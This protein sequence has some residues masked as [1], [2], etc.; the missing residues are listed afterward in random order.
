MQESIQQSMNLEKLSEG[1]LQLSRGGT[2]LPRETII[3]KD[4][5]SEAIKRVDTLA[6]E[7]NI[8]I[9]NRI[10]PLTTAGNPETLVQIVTI[11]LENAIKYSNPNSNIFIATEK[12]SSYALLHIRDEGIGISSDDLPHIFERFYR[13]DQSRGSHAGYGLGLSIALQLATQNNVQL[14]VESIPGKGSTF[15]IHF[16]IHNL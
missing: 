15:T 4:I 13:A 3:L 14:S 7:R 8:R 6:A 11:L 10:K 12:D 1:L 5:V 16:P 2:S 9:V